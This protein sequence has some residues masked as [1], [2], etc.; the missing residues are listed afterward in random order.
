MGVSA[1]PS[2]ETLVEAFPSLHRPRYAQALNFASAP[3]PALRACAYAIIASLVREGI[4]AHSDA[5]INAARI[6]LTLGVPQAV[7]RILDLTDPVASVHREAIEKLRRALHDVPAFPVESW[8]RPLVPIVLSCIRRLESLPGPWLGLA[9]TAALVSLYSAAP[10]Y[11]S[12]AIVNPR[13]IA[14]RYPKRP[15]TC[16]LLEPD[17]DPNTLVPIFEAYVNAR[18]V[19]FVFASRSH[20]ISGS[21]LFEQSAE[22]VTVLDGVPLFLGH[23]VYAK[24]Q[25]FDVELPTAG[26]TSIW[27]HTWRAHL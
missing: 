20:S 23:D 17:I 19:N 14:E 4:A 25:G 24:A 8:F 2:L 9:P 1:A 15:V 21:P 26:Q 3:Y 5:S 13:E 6:G 11:Y 16:V 18:V 27:L 12:L 10:G 7:R 22:P